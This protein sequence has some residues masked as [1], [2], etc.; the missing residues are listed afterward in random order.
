MELPSPRR[1]GI[2]ALVGAVGLLLATGASAREVEPV[3]FTYEAPAECPGESALLDMVARDGGRLVQVPDEH[4]ARSFRVRIRGG[5]LVRGSLIVRDA[6]GREAAREV[7][8]PD[9]DVVVRALAVL[10]ALSLRPPIST[11]P[12]PSTPEAPTSPPSESASKDKLPPA[13]ESSGA[14]TWPRPSE[15]DASSQST[16]RPHGWRLDLSLEGTESTGVMPWLDSAFAVY[17][18]LQDEIPSFL[19]PSIRLGTETGATQH[20]GL[21]TTAQ[22]FVVRLDA[23]SLRAVASSIWSDD[24]FTLEP[25]ARVDIGRVDFES[26]FSGT[27]AKWL[28][29]EPATLLRLR[30][31]TPTLFVEL[32]G[33]VTFPLNQA[34]WA[35]PSASPFSARMPDFVTPRIGATTGLG[36]GVYYPGSER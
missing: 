10:V 28:W 36:F 18:E 5:H 26:S 3:H 11:D 15:S 4:S 20:D 27:H 34:H 9:C 2:G 7:S 30:W 8:D 16:V 1:A 24:T 6:D 25:C 17:V 14:F 31:T 33:G 13:P 21:G 22:R 23:C 35:T 12:N 19:A 32:E 29:I